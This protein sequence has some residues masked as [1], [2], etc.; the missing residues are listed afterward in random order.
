MIFAV[1]IGLMA[2]ALGLSYIA[3]EL[4]RA[5]FGRCEQALSKIA[6]RRVLAIAIAGI[7]P[8]FLRAV[9]LPWVAPPSPAM[10][11]E[12]SYLLA[13]DTFA[14]GR[15]ANP[16]HPM[17]THF[18]TFHEI[19]QPTYASMY[20]PAQGFILAAGKIL[21]NPFIGV[22]LSIGAMCAA[23][24]WMLQGWLPSSWAF[25]GA[26]LPATN[27][28]VF[29]Y[30]DNSYWGGAPA[31]IG[32][33]LLLGSLP[34]IAVYGRAI[35]AMVMGL[36][37][38]I[39]ANSRPYEGFVLGVATIFGLAYCAVKSGRAR[40]AILNRR[41]LGALGLVL[42]GSGAA[43]C[44]Y[45]WRVTGNPVRMPVEVNRE[46]YG[47]APYFFGETAKRQPVYRNAVME[48]FY[49]TVEYQKYVE[50]HSRHGFVFEL[51]RKSAVT[52][53]FYIGPTLTVPLIMLPW[54]LR[55]RR[56][57]FLLFAGAIS[58]VASAAVIF[59]MAH[60][61]AA[62][63]GLLMA[64]VVQGFRHLRQWRWQGHLS[65]MFLAR[66]VI[67]I[68]VLLMPLRGWQLAA[69][70]KASLQDMAHQRARVLRELSAVSGFH[71]VLVRYKPGHDTRAEWVYNDADIDN[72]KVV[73]AR[74]MG[75]EENEQLTRYFNN[76]TVWWLE[77]DERPS[78]LLPFQPA[79]AKAGAR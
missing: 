11:D 77:A 62:I 70:S 10:H 27:F 63:T 53:A 78:K 26:L 58:F 25:L 76:R 55:D 46:A 79:M 43:T 21:G 2:F 36:G 57:R 41:V 68:C 9:L 37:L 72:A 47:M 42:L 20:P 40:Q 28:A 3:P 31:A 30:W 67:A 75:S 60:Y 51:L 73:W 49:S 16:T 71:L 38:A 74:D 29:S 65:G 44:F 35:D 1:E 22:W 32:G 48:A 5:W 59:F 66:A 4:G 45:F 23:I 33:A 24:C 39:L 34:R 64:V 69:E 50:S 7:L 52:W 54:V 15:L 17:W 12:F 61:V 14:H 56:I 19:F 18:E 6:G 8:L 13:A